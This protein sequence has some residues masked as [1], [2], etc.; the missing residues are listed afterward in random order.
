MSKN[1]ILKFDQKNKQVHFYFD[2]VK[3]TGF[4]GETLASALIANGIKL[5]GRSFKYHRPRG[6]MALGTEEPNALVSIKNGNE[7]EPNIQATQIEIYDA[8]RVES[9]NR[10]PNLRYDF[11]SILSLFSNLLPAGFYYKT[12]MWPSSMWK[13]YE[14]F[15]R[16]MSGL[17]KASNKELDSNKYEHINFHTDILIVGGGATGLLSAYIAGNSGLKVLIADENPSLGGSMLYENDIKIN[18]LSCKI[19]ANKIIKTLTEMKNVTILSRS[20]VFG[21]HD[22][23]YITISEKCHGNSLQISNLT[24]KQRLWMVRAKKV[25]L[26]QGLV[27]R[28]LTIPGN[29]IPGV[30]LSA[31]IRGYINKFGVLPGNEVVLCT[32]NDDTYRT[33]KELIRV[34]A[35]VKYVVDVRKNSSGKIIEEAKKLGIKILFNH[36]VTSIS[37]NK[38]VQ[39]VEICKLSNDGK[40]IINEP[41]TVEA[42]LVGLSGG[43]SPSVNLFSQSGGKLKW[44]KRLNCFKPHE[45]VQDEITVGGSDGVF[46]FE[47]SLTETYK[48]LN[49]I[50]KE[51]GGNVNN[52][53]N[54]EIHSP[55]MSNDIKPFWLI[56]SSESIKNQD[57]AFVDFQNDVVARDITIASDEGYQSIEHLKRYTTL[58]M[59]TDQGKTSNVAGIG[60][61]SEKIS[62][63]IPSIGTTTFRM[64]HTPITF[65]V[66]GGKDIKNLFD[67]IRLTKIDPWHR[68]NKAKFEHVGQW[69]RAWYYPRQNENMQNTINREVLNTRTNAGILDASTLGKI[70]IKGKDSRKF[71]NMIYT[72][73]WSKIQK[74]HCKYGIMLKEDGMVM[75]DGVTACIDD[76]HFHMTTTTGG[77]SNV[78]SW[79]EEWL[80]TEWPHLEVF[81]T[82]VTE[83]WS[84]ISI[85]GPNSREI[86]RQL[87]CD[88]NFSNEEFPFMT[89]KVG[90]I[91]EIPVKIF[92]ISFTGELSFEINVPSRYGL[93][94]WEKIFKT[95]IKYGLMPYGTETMHVLR[96]EKGFIITGQETDGSVNP[97]DLGMNWIISNKKKD[98][99]G[100]KS[101]SITSSLKNRKQLVGLL[102]N[103]PNKV[104]P[105]GAHAVKNINKRPP[106]E[107]LGHVTSSYYSPNCKRSIALALI[108]NG[109]SMYGEELFFPLLNNDVISA[110][111]VKPVF[112]DPKGEKLNGI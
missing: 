103:D 12:F 9:Q 50:V 104:L 37:G 70:D 74:G 5:V 76:N 16:K 19:W 94:L 64:P 66:I 112:F 69:M 28:P 68:K 32:N 71:L 98:F 60:I 97:N 91:E 22:H 11:G 77:A 61:L 105:E 56:P 24:P 33:A 48:K 101:L 100:K 55:S 29:D 57:K 46:N 39:K 58:G 7:I 25:V 85:S 40:K 38:E 84:V 106:F 42:N 35:N 95:G 43:W 51:F 53:L 17:G 99:I 18:F 21:Y 26:A 73:D 102:T 81:L 89:F 62:K 1:R 4:E 8:L 63:E 110:K 79:M 109:H 67:P 78:M 47:K 49:T 92:R 108:K 86:L 52:K 27:E 83:Q 2:G 14:H 44:D 6:I 54:L 10:W 59:G 23:N 65:G 34:N 96:A 45:H 90:S 15:I 80:Q 107:M 111:V 41:I 75:D 3:L 36:C 30:M 88:I 20:T 13:T 82:S 31:S 93:F 87:K 72:N